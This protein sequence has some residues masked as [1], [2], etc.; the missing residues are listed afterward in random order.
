MEIYENCIEVSLIQQNES[1]KISVLD[2]PTGRLV[3]IVYFVI[4]GLISSEVF[5]HT[6]NISTSLNLEQNVVRQPRKPGHIRARSTAV[7]T[8]IH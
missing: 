7:T 3:N 2:L 4:T 1:G 8:D 5:V 6:D